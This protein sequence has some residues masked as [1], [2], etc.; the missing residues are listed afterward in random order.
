MKIVVQVKLMPTP[1]VASALECTL[2]TANESANWLS[3]QAYERGET[4]RKALQGFAY[5]DLKARGLPAQP[6]LPGPLGP[7]S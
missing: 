1:E 5:H 3:A 2:R 4:S 6:A 7:G